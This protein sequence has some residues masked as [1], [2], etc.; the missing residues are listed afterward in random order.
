MTELKESLLQSKAV[1]SFVCKAKN[2]FIMRSN[3][4]HKLTI[5][6]GI[7]ILIRRV[8]THVNFKVLPQREHSRVM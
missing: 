4:S 8:S 6:E 7:V 2:H 3:S 1:L 5:K